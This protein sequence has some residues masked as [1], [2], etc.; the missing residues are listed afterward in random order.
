MRIYRIIINNLRSIKY[1]D[2]KPEKINL[3]IGGNNSGK[4][5]VLQA[6]D[7][8]LNPYKNWHEGIVTE[9]DFYNRNTEEKGSFSH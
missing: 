7:F 4:T 6:L 3:F 8:V 1:L 9:Y 5:N 2:F